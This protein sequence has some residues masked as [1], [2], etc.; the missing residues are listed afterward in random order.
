MDDGGLSD[1]T[2][3]EVDETPMEVDDSDPTPMEVDVSGSTVTSPSMDEGED[4][5]PMEATQSSCVRAVYVVRAPSRSAA[6][7]SDIGRVLAWGQPLVH[8][9]RSFPARGR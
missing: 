5:T 9:L 6:R 7:T 3:M 1:P 4:T 8:L 2:P